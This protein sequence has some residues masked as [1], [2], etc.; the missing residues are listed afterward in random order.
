MY[1]IV[2]Y[3]NTTISLLTLYYCY[4]YCHT[5]ST[6]S[7]YNTNTTL[8]Y[9][10][11]PSRLDKE[12]IIDATRRGGMA[13]FMNHCCEPNAYARVITAPSL[14]T[15]TSSGGRVSVGLSGSDDKHI[16]I[17]AARDIQVR[18]LLLLLYYTV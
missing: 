18:S 6:L 13:R 11:P 12:D 9:H 2:L 7:T 10:T 8:Y 16:I 5:T 15:T 4:D 17:M 3:I 14:C 1:C